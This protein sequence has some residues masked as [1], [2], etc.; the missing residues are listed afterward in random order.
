V[1][2]TKLVRAVILTGACVAP[3]LPLAAQT[4]TPVP[5]QAQ[6]GARPSGQAKEKKPFVFN[7]PSMH[8]AEQIPANFP[9]PAYTSNVTRKRF[10]NTIKGPP[11]ASAMIDT[12]D[13]VEMVYDWYKDACKRDNWI[14]RTPTPQAATKMSKSGKP[15]YMIEATKDK[16]HVLIF[17]NP[18]PKTG[19]TS[20]HM[21][22]TKERK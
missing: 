5:A 6:Q 10:L 22:W 21:N 19:G 14:Y 18:D 15:I 16:Q 4:P 17:C 1:H 20:V 3:T 12:K 7:I 9:I 8:Y 11:S 13:R 2:L